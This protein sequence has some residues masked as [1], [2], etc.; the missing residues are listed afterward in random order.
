MGALA[1]GITMAAYRVVGELPSGHK[2]QYVEALTRHRFRDLDPK[3]QAESLGWVN[4]ADASD[5]AFDYPKLYWGTYVVVG[6]RHDVIRIPASTFKLELA[7]AQAEY[8]AKAGRARLSKAEKD[9]LYDQ[10]EAALRRRA[11]PVVRTVDMVWNVDRARVWLW[12]T[13]KR[14]LLSFEDIFDRTFGLTLHPRNAY[15]MLEEL[16]DA[17]RWTSRVL[18]VAP[19]VLSALGARS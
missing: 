18:E 17:A 12:T 1:G 7:R 13:N 6:L 19:S 8:L 10:V 14:F 16:P 11:L 2:E 4:A 15:A 3:T 9:E 5:T